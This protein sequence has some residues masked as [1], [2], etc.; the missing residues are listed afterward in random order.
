MSALSELEE[1]GVYAKDL[2]GWIVASAVVH[3]AKIKL[4]ERVRD[5]WQSIAPEYG[6]RPPKHDPPTVYGTNWPGD[7]RESIEV[8]EDS[9][10]VVYVGSDFA[11]LADWIEYG[12]EHMP[13]YAP[14][15]QTLAHFGGGPVDAA[16]KLTGALLIG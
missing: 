5:Y 13:E 2:E 7:Y 10:G 4:A 16:S 14:G 15:M 12:N 3:E 11:P 1:A 6:D 9:D 8:H